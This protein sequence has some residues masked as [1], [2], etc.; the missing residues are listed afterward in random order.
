MPDRQ[1]LEKKLRKVLENCILLSIEE[2]NDF[3]QKIPDMP[4]FLLKKAIEIV[5]EK[6][7]T[8]TGYI[9][10]ALAL[11]S[12]QSYLQ[13]LNTQIKK[14]KAQAKAIYEKSSSDQADRDLRNQLEKLNA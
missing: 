6:N 5:Q 9:H 3:L 8:V 2:K 11:D 7:K 13:Q 14:D 12:Q 1:F 4:D 10:A